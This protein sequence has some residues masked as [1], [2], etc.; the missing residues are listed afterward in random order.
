M[1]PMLLPPPPLPERIE[2]ETAP[3]PPSLSSPVDHV[4]RWAAQCLLMLRAA[5]LAAAADAVD[6]ADARAASRARRGGGWLAPEESPQRPVATADRAM[7]A[8]QVE[9]GSTM[10]SV[11]AAL[12]P[13]LLLLMSPLMLLMPPPPLE[14]VDE[15]AG[16]LQKSSRGGL[17]PLLIES[18]LPLEASAAREC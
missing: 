4:A 17:A 5:E 11:A 15:T 8:A 7:A 2:V 12:P 16:W 1:P 10:L 14:R 3:P 9:R 13:L 6:A 18:W